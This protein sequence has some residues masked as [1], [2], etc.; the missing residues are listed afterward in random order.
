[1]KFVYALLL[2]TIVLWVSYVPAQVPKT[3]ARRIIHIEHADS[4]IGNVAKYGKNVQ[5]LMGNVRFRHENTLM[6]CDSA[7]FQRDSNKMDAY[8]SVHIV[9][10]DSIHLYGKELYY[11]GNED[12]AKVRK[13]VRLVN[14]ESV[15]TTEYLDYDRRNDVAYYFNDG[16]I[17]NS[18]NVLVSSW[19]YYFP[20]TEM[21]QF[22]D[23]VVV[24]NPDYTMYSDTLLYFTQTEIVKIAGATTI[25]SEQN[26]IYSEAGFYDTKKDIARLEKNSAVYAREQQLYGD[27][28]YYDRTS[29]FAEVFSNMEM[30]DTT[31]NIIITGNYGYYNEFTKNALA[32]RKA[33]LKQVYQGDTLFLHADTLRTDSIPEREHR[34]VR[35]YRNVKF[36]RTD[37]QGRCDSMVYDL[38]DSI[39]TLYYE[40]II[41]SQENQMT[42]E[43]V[44][45]YTRQNALY[46]AELI[47]DAF[48]ISREDTVH[49]NQIKGK[50]M[51]GY[52]RDNELHRIDVDGNGQTVYYPKDDGVMI[53]V[54]RTESSNLT[55]LLENRQIEGI[56]T[57]VQPAGNLN[58]P[59][60]IPLE[61][62]RL[63]SFRWLDEY[64]PKQMSDIFL[65]IAPPADTTAR[66]SSYSDY[67][68]DVTL[69]VK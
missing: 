16:K 50:L 52:I 56:T 57:R 47:N 55:I 14:K 59:L 19:G 60:L 66:K 29:G 32:T 9:Q 64:R 24:T 30:H 49:F 37:F 21:A 3:P 8:G 67:I 33:V 51:T 61:A 22:R 48:I 45:L 2:T 34:L 39:N 42:A 54:N 11:Y 15:L 18:D 58:P 53:G 5:V 25:L 40:P 36:Y 69:P 1:M 68:D 43:T 13:D 20:K 7:Y 17:T 44:K 27:T 23:S 46:K 4:S 28:I 31:N 38:A 10:N 26:T 35:A 62:Q 12:M 63:E 65:H 41:W 6:Y